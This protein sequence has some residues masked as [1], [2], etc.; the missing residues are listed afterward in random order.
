MM[1]IVARSSFGNRVFRA[2]VTLISRILTGSLPL[3]A[4]TVFPQTGR[5]LEFGNGYIVLEMYSACCSAR[6][7]A[8]HITGEAFERK[9]MATGAEVGLDD[10]GE[11]A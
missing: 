8:C 10:S 5:F 2:G 7:T 11:P 9:T 3:V 4:C 6:S 1:W